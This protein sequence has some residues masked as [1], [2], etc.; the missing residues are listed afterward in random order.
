MVRE[1]AMHNCTN[2]ARCT[3]DDDPVVRETLS[4]PHITTI[5]DQYI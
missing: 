3:S 2:L 5:V 4:D 1:H